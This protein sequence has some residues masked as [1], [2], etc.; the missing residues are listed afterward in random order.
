[1]VGFQ[2]FMPVR[3]RIERI[4]ANQDGAGPF[5]LIKAQKVVGETENGTRTFVAAPANGLGQRV[6]GPVGKR[7]A[8][9]HEQWAAHGLAIDPPERARKAIRIGQD[10]E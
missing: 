1:L 5:A 10:G 8:V 3:R 6:I 7:I 2:R 4:P 9:D